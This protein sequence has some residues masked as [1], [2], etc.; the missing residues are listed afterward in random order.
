MLEIAPSSYDELLRQE[1][2]SE[3]TI[4]KQQ[5]VG[6]KNLYITGLHKNQSFHLPEEQISDEEPNIERSVFNKFRS[7]IKFVPKKII[8]LTH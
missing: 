5:L 2:E 1:I 3:S 4:I 7:R 6:R 8:L